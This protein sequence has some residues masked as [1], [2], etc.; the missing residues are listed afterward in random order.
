MKRF[1]S[2]GLKNDWWAHWS[3]DVAGCVY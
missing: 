3:W 2:N 1:N